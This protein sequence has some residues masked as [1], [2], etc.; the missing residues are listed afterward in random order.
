MALDPLEPGLALDATLIHKGV[1]ARPLHNALRNVSAVVE[2]WVPLP[3]E[4]LARKF[5]WRCVKDRIPYDVEAL[6]GFTLGSRH[7]HDLSSMYCFEYI[8]AIWRAGGLDDFD[9]HRMVTGEDLINVAIAKGSVRD[10]WLEAQPIGN[11]WG[12]TRDY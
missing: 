8:A 4:D 2:L 5:A 1:K 10:C 11:S 3:D 6:W 7:W 9:N 12:F